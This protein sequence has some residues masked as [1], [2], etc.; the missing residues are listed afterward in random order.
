MKPWQTALIAAGATGAAGV[1]IWYYLYRRQQMELASDIPASPQGVTAAQS[2]SPR[3][4]QNR[5]RAN[6]AA[7]PLQAFLDWWDTNG[8]FPLVVAPDGGVRTDAAKQAG[9]YAAGTS[10]AKTLDQ[11]PHG[12]A[13][14]LDLWPAGFNPR[15][16]LDQQPDIKAKFKQMGAIAKSQFNFTWGGDW[17]WDYPHVEVKGWKNMP[18]PPKTGLAGLG[19]VDTTSAGSGAAVAFAIAAGVY[20]LF[21][22]DGDE[23]TPESECEAAARRWKK[24]CLIEK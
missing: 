22:R 14:A 2:A 12:R 20:F 9:Y 15:V 16:P 23:P 21:L 24:T 10:K 3:L 19:A 13:A 17:G 6:G 18:Y 7:A 11:T 4:V 8:P 5:E 1:G